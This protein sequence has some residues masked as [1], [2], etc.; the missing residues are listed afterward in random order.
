MI[1]ALVEVHI[2]ESAYKLNLVEE[3]VDSLSIDEYYKALFAQKEYSL[4]E[5]RIS[6]DYYSQDPSTIER[7][8]DSTLTRVQMME[9]N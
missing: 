2:L 8:L 9:T 5:F 4:D 1:D 7:L 3:V 6:F